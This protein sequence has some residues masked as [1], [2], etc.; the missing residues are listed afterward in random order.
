MGEFWVKREGA[1]GNLL[2]SFRERIREGNDTELKNKDQ[3]E[4]L[5]GG[6]SEV[7]YLPLACLPYLLASCPFH[8][9][10]PSG[11]YGASR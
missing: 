10:H 9:R 4:W 5:A 7:W 3:V 8:R 2:A 1:A 11:K 6:G